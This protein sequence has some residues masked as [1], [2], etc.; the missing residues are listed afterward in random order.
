MFLSQRDLIGHILHLSRCIE[1]M[2]DHSARE[3]GLTGSQSRV[4]CFLSIA[5]LEQDVYQK[6]VEEAFGVRPSSATGLLQALELQG[7]IRREAVSRDARLKKIILTEK[8][9]G[10]QARVVARHNESLRHLR[11]NWS[12][13][14][15]QTFIKGCTEVAER[16]GQI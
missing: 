1:R 9:R 10:I 14:E 12:R 5:S 16:A 6:D 15:L 13:E 2:C 8:G 4:F 7:F 11:G 3:T